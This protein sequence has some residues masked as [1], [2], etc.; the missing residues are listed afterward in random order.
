M[1][2]ELDRKR[3]EKLSADIAQVIKAYYLAGP[4]GR[5]RV[6]EVLNALA[7]NVA[8]IL[9]GVSEAGF[10]DC[11]AFFTKALQMQVDQTLSELEEHDKAAH[12]PH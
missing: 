11:L 10:D 12:G 9:A 4:R 7:A 5:G 3:V 2:S 6:L 1:P 8:M